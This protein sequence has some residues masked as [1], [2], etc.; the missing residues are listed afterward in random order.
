MLY[1][2]LFP[3]RSL[4][5]HIF[6]TVGSTIDLVTT[7]GIVGQRAFMASPSFELEQP[8]C[9]QIVYSRSSYNVEE[10]SYITVYEGLHRYPLAGTFTRINHLHNATSGHL[11]T[12]FDLSPGKRQLQIEGTQR[13]V[14]SKLHISHV[15]LTSGSCGHV[16]GNNYCK[17]C[18]I[19]RFFCPPRL[20]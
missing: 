17:V 19:Y 5:L 2:C 14:G 3:D 11:R 6:F 7:F 4:I 20:A 13:D 16:I 1:A 9:A 15:N 18:L 8:H 10:I 12:F